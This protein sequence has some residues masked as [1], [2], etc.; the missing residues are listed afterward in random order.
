M[1][2][3]WRGLELPGRVV[4][5]TEVN[6]DSYGLFTVEPFE[7]G[8]GTTIGNSL[9]RVLL[10]CLEGA[11]VTTVKIEGVAHEFATIDGVMEDVTDIVLNIKGII[12]KLDGADAKSMTIERDTAGVVRAGDFV[13]DPAVTIVNPDH[14]IATLTADVPF[15]IRLTVESGRGY[16]TAND[17]RPIAEEIGVI[18]IDSVFS[19]VLRVRYKTEAMRVG[20]KTNYDR[21]ILEV[22]TDGSVFPEDAIIE[23]GMILRKHLNP[24]IMYNRL[25]FDEVPPIDGPEKDVGGESNEAFD[26]LL[27]KPVSALNLSVR[28][29]NCL[30]AARVD[31]IRELVSRTEADLLR[32]RSFGKT[33]LNEVYRKLEDLGLRLGMRFGEGASGSAMESAT[34]PAIGSLTQVGDSPEHPSQSTDLSPEGGEMGE[35]AT[36]EPESSTPPTTD[37]DPLAAFT[38]E[39]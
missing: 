32:V 35:S 3:R 36:H 30:E 38:M 18:P 24:F 37:S 17:N 13:T 1:R 19:P 10:S 4:P 39:D 9:R 27:D 34:A 25:G 20:Q 15:H 28:A 31:T 6:S 23:A 29:N 16:A 26:E 11:A 7:Q 21:L 14:V 5:N 8:F 2:I 12:I 22:W 33:S